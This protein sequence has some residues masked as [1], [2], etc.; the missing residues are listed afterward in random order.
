MTYAQST[1]KTHSDG[2]EEPESSLSYDREVLS[3]D[4]VN[5][6]K[7]I[8]HFY[9]DIDEKTAPQFCRNLLAMDDGILLLRDS[10]L[11]ICYPLGG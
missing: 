1:G 4:F 8:I 6:D 2:E 9:G 10:D 11:H 7:R 3:E 5:T